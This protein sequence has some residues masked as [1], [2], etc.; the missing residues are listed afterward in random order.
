[1]E[2]PWVVEWLFFLACEV[3][4]VLRNYIT[5][6]DFSLTG[7]WR[8]IVWSIS[9]KTHRLHGPVSELYL[10]EHLLSSI[11]LGDFLLL[12]YLAVSQPIFLFSLSLA[13]QGFLSVPLVSLLYR[14][15]LITVFRDVL[16]LPILRLSILTDIPGINI[17][18]FSLKSLNPLFILHFFHSDNSL[19]LDTLHFYKTHRVDYGLLS[20]LILP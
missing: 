19:V 18:F 10:F 1:M 9:A 7:I 12:E 11:V 6:V 13:F 20:Q 16:R 17:H 5:H 2:R 4:R 3:S 14:H 15:V 8:I